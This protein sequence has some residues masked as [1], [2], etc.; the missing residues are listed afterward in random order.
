MTCLTEK[1]CLLDTLG[2]GMNDGAWAVSSMLMNQQ[3]T[4]NKEASNRSTQET[5]LC[6]HQMTKL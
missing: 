2:S 1:I 6:I 5:R 3:C 4:V